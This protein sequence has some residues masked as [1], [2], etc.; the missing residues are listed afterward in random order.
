[1]ITCYSD[2]RVIVY[3]C[4]VVIALQIDSCVT[5]INCIH[6]VFAGYNIEVSVFLTDTE[7]HRAVIIDAL[8]QRLQR[9]N[10]SFAEGLKISD[11]ALDIVSHILPSP[12][13]FRESDALKAL[14][15]GSDHLP[16]YAELALSHT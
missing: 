13:D 15:V 14:R 9:N 6:L 5:F 4:C 10:L 11:D 8:S 12:V 7:T 3:M 2:I 16:I 1:M